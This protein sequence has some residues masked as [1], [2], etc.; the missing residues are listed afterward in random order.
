[1]HGPT[2]MGSP[3]AC[4]VANASI[5]LLLITDW[6]EN[7]ERIETTLNTELQHFVAL[8]SVAAIRLLGAI[9]VIEIHEPV[10][11]AE[12]QKRFVAEGVWVRRFGKLVY[13]MP[14][15]ISTETELKSLMQGV[16]KVL[17]G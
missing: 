9:G 12:I 13:V 4:A 14:P 16:F 11:V 1:M 15:F 17:A 8:Q 2:S 5:D 7:I 6:Q 3:L 10:N